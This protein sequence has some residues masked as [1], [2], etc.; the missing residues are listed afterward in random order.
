MNSLI[1][2]SLPLNTKSHS[3]SLSVAPRALLALLIQPSWGS[4]DPAHDPLSAPILVR[5]Q[6]GQ[7]PVPCHP[8]LLGCGLP[9]HQTQVLAQ[10]L[11]V[12]IPR[13]MCNDWGCLA[14]GCCSGIGSDS[15][16]L[17]K[18]DCGNSQSFRCQAAG[19]PLPSPHT[20]IL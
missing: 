12:P 17:H 1:N 11:P 16:A 19:S 14:P 13:E 4:H 7:P 8:A 2:T 10:A 18:W 9:S 5:S 3:H 15:W 6:Q 20:D